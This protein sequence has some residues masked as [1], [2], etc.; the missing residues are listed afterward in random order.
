VARVDRAGIFAV[1]GPV[2]VGHPRRRRAR[3]EKNAQANNTRTTITA[4]PT[5]T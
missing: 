4:A 3:Q 5:K 1:V 2:V